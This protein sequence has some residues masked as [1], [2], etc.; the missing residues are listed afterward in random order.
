MFLPIRCVVDIDLF[1]GAL[2]TSTSFDVILSPSQPS[3]CF[4]VYF[5]NIFYSESGED[6]RHFT[7]DSRARQK[8]HVAREKKTAICAPDVCSDPVSVSCRHAGIA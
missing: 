1:I 5:I 4:S 8:S 3:L 6:M 7:E 2:S